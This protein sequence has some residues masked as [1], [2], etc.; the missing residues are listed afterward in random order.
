MLLLTLHL[1]ARAQ[2]NSAGTSISVRRFVAPPYPVLAWIARVQGTVDTEVTVRPDGTVQAANAASA[3]PL[4]RQSAETA[5]KQWL[6]QPTSEATTIKISIRFQ[7]DA[8][9]PQ[10][11]LKD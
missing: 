4:L 6:F 1:G 11:G 10:T 8:D 7:L 2:T 9:C 5:I 3:Y